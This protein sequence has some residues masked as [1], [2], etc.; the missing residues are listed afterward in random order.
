MTAS[1]STT[2]SSLGG[3]LDGIRVLDLSWGSVGAIA[4]MLLAD[5]GAEVV[6]VDRPG[7]D[8]VR[9]RGGF[10]TWDRG[11]HSAELDLRDHDD[12]DLVHRLAHG[13]DVIVDGLGAG[14]TAAFGLSY[15]DVRS[16]NPGLVY[17]SLSGAGPEVQDPMLGHDL[18][19]AARFGV[20]AETGGHRPGPIF[21]GHPATSYATGLLAC[22]GILAT[23]RSRLSTGAGDRVDISNLD[24]VLALSTMEWWSERGISFIA[25]KGRDNRLDLGRRALLLQHYTCADGGILQVNTAAPGAF[26]RAMQVFDLTDRI[27]VV[28]QG[29]TAELTDADLDVLSNALPDIVASRPLE[30][31]LEELWKNRIACLPVL[32]PGAFFDDDQIRHAGVI[33]TVKHSDRGSI[34]VVGPTISLSRSPAPPLG[35]IESVGDST[36]RVRVTPWRSQGLGWISNAD[37]AEAAPTTGGPLVGVRILE[38]SSFFASPYGN[39]I[40]ADL[41]ADVVKVEPPG[42][43]PQRAL[44]DPAENVNAHKRS[45]VIDL[46]NPATRP[47]VERLLAWADVVGHNMRPGAAERL[48]LGEAD[49]RDTNP[50]VIYTYGPGFGSSGPKSWLQSFAP[51]HSGLMGL[52]LLAAGEGNEPVL[53]FG[54]ED[55]YTGLLS[56]VGTLLALVHRDRTGEGQHVEVSQS[57]STAFTASEFFRRDGVTESTLG[58]L[59]ARQMGWSAYVRLYECSDGWLCVS[60]LHD[61]ACHALRSLAGAHPGAGAGNVI[62]DDE[63]ARRL[64]AVMSTGSVVERREDLRRRG[65]PCEV[66][67]PEPWLSTYLL[68]DRNVECGN[69]IEIVSAEHGRIRVIG[70]LFRSIARSNEGHRAPLTNEHAQQVLTELGLGAATVEDP[71]TSR[72]AE[73]LN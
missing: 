51:L 48:G 71:H 4:T 55:Y 17:C 33:Q 5:H 23:L 19:V 13:A 25:G 65:V 24:G 6:R 46:K 40:L 27:S 38:M 56:A 9:R 42:G 18:L 1:L 67:R 47:V 41:G 28:G 68:D 34:D 14:R 7:G 3:A 26:D 8:P 62:D 53:P 59:D 50:N 12:L 58:R 69:V 54:N 11:K 20:M 72:A 43:D 49:V 64:E 10:A 37:P 29:P 15:D 36:E 45:I 61:D 31:W 63:V 57:L 44:P 73:I 21:P 70:N 2:S 16:S 30:H 52:M 66:A 32:A 39:R 60:A 22:I 35:S